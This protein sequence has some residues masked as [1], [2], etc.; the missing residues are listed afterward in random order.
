MRTDAEAGTDEVQVTKTSTT[1]EFAVTVTAGTYDVFASGA[2]LVTF[3]RRQLANVGFAGRFTRRPQSPQ[4]ASRPHVDRFTTLY[5]D[6]GTNPL[7]MEERFPATAEVFDL[8]SVS[9][10]QRREPRARRR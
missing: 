1:G 4:A 2:G 3:A 9:L 7:G 6:K 10:L 8:N 5:N